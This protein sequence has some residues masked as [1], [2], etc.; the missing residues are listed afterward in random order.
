[1]DAQCATLSDSLALGR[2]ELVAEMI[3]SLEG[4]KGPIDAITWLCSRVI[5]RIEGGGYV[6]ELELKTSLGEDS[7]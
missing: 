4:I 1:M 6:T 3:F 2:P 7:A 5:H